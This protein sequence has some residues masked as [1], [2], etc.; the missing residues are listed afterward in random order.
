M[1]RK[2]LVSKKVYANNYRRVSKSGGSAAA[3]T[4]KTTSV[5][6]SQRLTTNREVDADLKTPPAVYKV[7]N[8]LVQ[9]IY[10]VQFSR[11][12]FQLKTSANVQETWR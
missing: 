9:F 4:E 8:K 11:V 12:V 6:S 7:K 10:S 2:T 1:P 3:T 5:R